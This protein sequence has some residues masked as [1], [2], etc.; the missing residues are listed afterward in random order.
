MQVSC[1]SKQQPS[2]RSPTSSSGA[3]A[4]IQPARASCPQ[5]RRGL[6]PPPPFLFTDCQVCNRRA[7]HSRRSH[8][9][10]SK[11]QVRWTPS[12]RDTGHPGRTCA[13]STLPGSLP[14]LLLRWAPCSACSVS[15]LL[16]AA[17]SDKASLRVY[18]HQS[19]TWQLRTARSPAR[20]IMPLCSWADT[21]YRCGRVEYWTGSSVL[22]VPAE[23]SRGGSALI[24]TPRHCD[25]IHTNQ[26][27][28]SA[29]LVHSR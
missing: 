6:S 29:C 14:R 16:A 26:Q 2:Q 19:H 3:E 7:R 25:S 5:R 27:R 20:S 1:Q 21:G 28:A 4:R 18:H 8:A 11:W 22:C 23:S 24:G 9:K 12:A 13:Q 10:R 15:G 17:Q